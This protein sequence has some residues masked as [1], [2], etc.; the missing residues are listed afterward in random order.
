M[1]SSRISYMV[2]PVNSVAAEE[3]R[4][5]AAYARRKEE[6]VRYSWFNP[7][8][9]FMMHQRERKLLALL[10]ERGL[11]DLQSRSILEIG[12]GIGLWLRDLVK[13]GA[14]PKNVT[15]IDLLWDRVSR[16]RRLCPAGVGIQCASAAELPFASEKFDLVLQS[17]VFTSILDQDLK[18]RVAAEMMRVVKPGGV[19]I[20]YDYHVDNPWNKDVRGIKR[21]EIYELFPSCQVALERTTLLPP[22]ARWLA[23]YSFSVCYFLEKIPLLC[24]HYMG[25][26]RRT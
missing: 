3:S 17:T 25:F 13:W 21:R 8:Y 12:C 5:R 26:I 1:S 24:T 19:I 7:A 10:S 20:W 9:Q 15:G 6:D 2:K 16:A 4:I 22:L 23:P 18:R 14:Q 11:A